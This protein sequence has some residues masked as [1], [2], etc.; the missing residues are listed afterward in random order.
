MVQTVKN[1]PAAQETRVQSLGREDP[2]KKAHHFEGNPVDEST[3]RRGT[4][5]PVHRPQRPA[6]IGGRLLAGVGEG[7]PDVLLGVTIAAGNA[8]F[9]NSWTA[10]CI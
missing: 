6:R 5:T 7:F 1:L 10:S 4:D 9:V 3:S 8:H 2:L